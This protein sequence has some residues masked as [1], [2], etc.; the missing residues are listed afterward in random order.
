MLTRTGT[1]MNDGTCRLLWLRICGSGV[2]KC[3]GTFKSFWS[4]NRKILSFKIITQ[5]WYICMLTSKIFAR[6]KD[7]CMIA[8]NIFVSSLQIYLYPYF[9]YTIAS[10]IFVSLLQIYFNAHFKDIC[11]GN[12]WGSASCPPTLR[13]VLRIIKILKLW[14]KYWE[15]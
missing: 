3:P 2:A 14:V 8:S 1:M 13:K 7:I 12:W 11:Q 9:K 15:S 5:I 10:N 4:V 6:F